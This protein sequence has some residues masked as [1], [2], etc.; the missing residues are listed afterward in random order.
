MSTFNEHGEINEHDEDI[1]RLMLEKQVGP[2]NIPEK[3][4]PRPPRP[5]TQPQRMFPPIVIWTAVGAVILLVLIGVVIGMNL[6]KPQTTATTNTNPPAQAEVAITSTVR[7]VAVA[8]ATAPPATPTPAVTPTLDPQ[9][10]MALAYTD[11][12][13]AYAQQDWD[14]AIELFK[15]VYSQ[16]E[17]YLDISEKLSATY[18]NWGVSLLNTREFVEALDKFN[19]TLSVTPDHQLALEQQTRLVLYLDAMSAQGNGQLRDAAVKLEE[20]R[21][22]QADYLD[23]TDMLYTIYMEYGAQLENQRKPTDALRI[24]QKAV[25]L[26]LEDVRAA[27]AKIR[28]LT[29]TPTPVPANPPKLRFSVYNYND[30]PTCISIGIN[31]ISTGGWYFT[32]DGV[33]G[34]V[35]YFDG[36]GNARAC[37][38]GYGQEVTITV[39][40]GSG[41]GVPGG[42]GVPS[43]GSAIMGATWR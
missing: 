14:K 19:A 41:Q 32:V 2:I 26:P 6:V 34:V 27:Q 40:D 9:A 29:P 1:Q 33:R 42:M 43:K 13:E 35:G 37:G 8:S 18:Y 39:H 21:E 25:K 3:Q 10:K 24:Y 22:I 5:G 12:V 28:A 11:G 4:I 36:G 17:N 31:G 7:A 15:R 20:L 16:D 23:S 38:L 30:D